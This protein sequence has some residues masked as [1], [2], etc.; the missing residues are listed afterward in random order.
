M[1]TFIK[2]GELRKLNIRVIYNEQIIY[3]GMSD[4]APGEIKELKY[5]SIEQNDVLT[6]YVDGEL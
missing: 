6:C 3:E 5:S 4:E 2:I 1:N